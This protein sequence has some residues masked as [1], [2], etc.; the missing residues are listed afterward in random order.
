[1]TD[2]IT[3]TGFVA[4]APRHLVTG[5]GLPITSFRLAS[6]QRRYDRRAAEWVDGETNW[7]TVTGFRQL[8]VHTAASVAKGDRVIVT[9]RLRIRDWSSGERSG[10]TIEVEAEALGHDLSWGTAAF[11]RA[12]PS[13]VLRGGATAGGDTATAGRSAAPTSNGAV[14]SA[15]AGVDPTAPAERGTPGEGGS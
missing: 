1:M 14:E 2:T 6:T 13:A 3:L 11:T 12:A 9:G 7:Y 4:T 5:E 10:T 15:D 8:A